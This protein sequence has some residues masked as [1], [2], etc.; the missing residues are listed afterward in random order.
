MGAG[1]PRHCR[2][3][4]IDEVPG[5]LVAGFARG[6]ALVLTGHRLASLGIAADV[7]ATY[8][9]PLARRDVGA[10]RLAMLIDPNP[11]VT[12]AA[13][14]LSLA[15]PTDRANALAAVELCKLAGLLPAAFCCRSRATL[16]AV[17]SPCR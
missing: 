6:T 9:L 10:G 7:A 17:T 2:K 4:V 16:Q 5:R 14:I 3:S 8:L 15:V 12:E 1:I 13:K 11:P